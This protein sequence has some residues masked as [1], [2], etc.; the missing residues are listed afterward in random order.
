MQGPHKETPGDS[1]VLE[2][3]AAGSLMKEVM[4]SISIHTFN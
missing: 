3:K 1:R 4:N 2:A